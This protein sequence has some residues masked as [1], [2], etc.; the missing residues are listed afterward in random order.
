MSLSL[1]LFCAFPPLG[2]RLTSLCRPDASPFLRVC[3]L[4]RPTSRFLLPAW[5]ASRRSLGHFSG[6]SLQYALVEKGFLLRCWSLIPCAAPTT[7]PCPTTAPSLCST[8]PPANAHFL[9]PPPRSRAGL[10]LYL[11]SYSHVTQRWCTLLSLS[12][13]T[14]PP[15]S[16]HKP[17][18]CSLCGDRAT[19]IDCKLHGD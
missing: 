4:L 5:Y 11:F 8:V 13:S 7:P 3:S 10:C 17:P 18:H 6:A 12:P 14:L 19:H 2:Q 16:P 9:P 15:P 1:C